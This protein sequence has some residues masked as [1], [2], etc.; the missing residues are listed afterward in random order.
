MSETIIS[1]VAR[2]ISGSAHRII[3]SLEGASP[4]AVMEEAVREIN[5]AV[6]DVKAELGKVIAAKH[7]LVKRL[8]E[9]RTKYHDLDTNISI[10]LNENR[11]DLAEAAVARQIDIEV[12]LPVLEKALAENY[13]KEK[14][15]E[16]YL[17]ALRG[18]KREMRE[19]L[20]TINQHR[21]QGKGTGRGIPVS[22]M[23][24]T[25]FEEKATKAENAF[26]RAMENST[27]FASLSSGDLSTASKLHELEELSRKNRIKER[28]AEI[29]AR[30]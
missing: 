19:E 28:L 27:G 29:K 9:T 21:N 18:K 26:N 17:N 8:E 3:D 1:K 5:E 12:Q 16:G 7:F 6:F 11:E 22:G 20:K 2:I 23:G 13:D 15:L 24:E 30:R 10:A 4:E 14:E 25:E